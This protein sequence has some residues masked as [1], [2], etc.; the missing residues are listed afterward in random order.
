[1]ADIPI[2]RLVRTRRRTLS[3]EVTAEGDVV[4]RAPLRTPLNFIQHF[5]KE[6]EDWIL[7][8]VDKTRQKKSEI[9]PR[10]Y[11]PGEHFLFLGHT[12]PLLFHNNFEKEPFFF[13]QGFFLSIEHQGKAKDLFFQWYIKQAMDIFP[14]RTEHYSNLTGLQ[15]RGIR[16]TNPKTRWG[17]CSPSGNLN[18]NWR[19]VMAPLPVLDYV[20][21]HE[22]VHLEVKN[23]SRKFWN[24]VGYFY[25][26][27]TEHRKW[28]RENGHRLEL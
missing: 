26:G 8:T 21:I 22:M 28:L 17:S 18:F 1:M 2:T 3:I 6:K 13:N 16:I 14:A 12:Y 19:L 11:S 7:K 24:K 15:N 27:Y 5:I 10:L 23:H 25:P 20:V 9:P 4:I